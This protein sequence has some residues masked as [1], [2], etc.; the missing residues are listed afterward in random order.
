MKQKLIWIGAGLALLGVA[1]GGGWWLGRAGISAAEN[2]VQTANADRDRARAELARV[3]VPLELC[4]AA[5]E[6]AKSN[7]GNAAERVAVAREAA[8]QVPDLRALDARFAEA[9][10]AAQKTDAKARERVEALLGEVAR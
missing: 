9:I 6:L 1:F 10:E 5:G 3:K 7:F 2:Q 4:R 8:R